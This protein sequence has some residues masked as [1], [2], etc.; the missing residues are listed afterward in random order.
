MAAGINQFEAT[1]PV[2]QSSALIYILRMG[3][4][5]L[6]GKLLQINQ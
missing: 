3:D 2:K 4:K 1:L 5:Q 6:S